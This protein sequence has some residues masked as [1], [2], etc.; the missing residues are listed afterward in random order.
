VRVVGFS[1]LDVFFR[2]KISKRENLKGNFT[3]IFSVVLPKGKSQ[4][5]VF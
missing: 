5:A 3:P 2:K 4:K 1:K